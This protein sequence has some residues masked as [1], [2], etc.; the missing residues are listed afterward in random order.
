MLGYKAP[1][2]GRLQTGVLAA[3]FPGGSYR[4][5]VGGRRLR[6]APPRPTRF[7]LSLAK[8]RAKIG[9][10]VL[11]PQGLVAANPRNR[12]L[13]SRPAALGGVVVLTQYPC[14]T[15]CQSTIGYCLNVG[16][17]DLEAAES[18]EILSCRIR[19]QGFRPSSGQNESR[20]SLLSGVSAPKFRGPKRIVSYKSKRQRRRIEAASPSGASHAA[21]VV[22]GESASRSDRQRTP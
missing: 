16:K 18:D 2:D 12:H 5:S 20:V 11:I 4:P 9:V 19:E 1:Q 15:N 6:S 17:S 7:L 21:K 10:A 14:F 3:G 8:M 22:R 13:L